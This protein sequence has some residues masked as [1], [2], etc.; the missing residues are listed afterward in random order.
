M[1]DVASVSF[2]PEPQ[3]RVDRVLARCLLLPM[4]S[5]TSVASTKFRQV[6]MINMT[7]P[8]S[9]LQLYHHPA[10]I[11]MPARPCLLLESY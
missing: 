8:D 9:S 7:A 5:T 6:T 4:L 1:H 3:C 10:S 2:I 11:F